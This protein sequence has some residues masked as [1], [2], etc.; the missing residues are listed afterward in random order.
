MRAAAAFLLLFSPAILAADLIVTIP[1]AAVP[2][3]IAR[4]DTQR[5]A[6]RI[7]AVD[8]SNDI[9]ATI[10]VRLGLRV[11]TEAD[12]EAA[13]RTSVSAAENAAAA[14]TAA[15][16]VAFDAD[17][18]YPVTSAACGDSILDTEFGEA[19]DDGNTV[20]GDGC[21]ADCQIETASADVSWD[22][23]ADAEGYRVYWREPVDAY[24][25]DRVAGFLRCDAQGQPASCL[26][27][28][29]GAPPRCESVLTLPVVPR[30]YFVATSFNGSGESG[31]SNEVFK[32][33]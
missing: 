10:M 27:C 2:N 9:C 31:Q 1:S 24:G 7:R 14:T 18:P 5:I 30:W 26:P 8:W 6:L 11:L 22:D 33:F 15:A 29:L 13:G 32:D 17:F 12:S 19:C 23:V 3:A 25:N 21:T 4:C 20:D 28:D 16:L